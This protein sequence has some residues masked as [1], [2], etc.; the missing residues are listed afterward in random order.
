MDLAGSGQVSCA[1]ANQQEQLGWHEEMLQH[2]S[3]EMNTIT[4]HLGEVKGMMQTHVTEFLVNLP[5]RHSPAPPVVLQP[6]PPPNF[7][8]RPLPTPE[9]VR[10]RW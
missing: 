6:S 10:E 2:I 1:L 4:L 5:V 9:L 3:G 7:L 8:K